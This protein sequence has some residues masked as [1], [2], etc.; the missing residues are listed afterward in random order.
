MLS[1]RFARADAPGFAAVASPLAARLAR[2]SRRR[3]ARGGVAAVAALGLLGFASEARASGYLTARYGS[4]MGTPA[5]P[6]AYAV[7]YNPAAMG[8][9]HGTNLIIDASVVARFASY[10]RA[11]T[12]PSADCQKDP[13]CVAANTGKGT[14]K[15]LLAL[16]YI[17]ATTDLG[18]KDFRLGLAGYIPYGGMATWDKKGG[19]QG[20]PG[21][22]DGPQRWH[23][24][25]GTILAMHAT[26]AASYTLPANL[27][28]GASVSG[29]YHTVGTVR[30][31]NADDGD[32]VRGPDGSLTEGR[33]YLK[34]NAFNVGATFG[35]YWAPEKTGSRALDHRLKLGVS[36]T[37]QPGF[38]ETRMAGELTQ[39][40]GS[41]V[42]GDIQKIDFLQTYPDIIRFGA[43]YKL[44]GDKWELKADVDFVRW[45]VFDRQC[46][47]LA[48]KNCNIDSATGGP[49]G[50]NDAEKAANSRDVVL[51]LKRDWQNA[52]G[53]R[54][55][56]SYFL[57]PE[58]ELF[59]SLGFSTSAVPKA[60]IDAN[61]IDSFRIYAA[62]GLRYELSKRLT[63]AGS[64]NHIFFMPVDNT[65]VSVYAKNL[66]PSRSPSAEGK[67]SST[68]GMLNANATL[69]F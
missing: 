18:T 40:L 57:S 58:V 32:V 29:I 34:A 48:G 46:V 22:T 63:L 31:R 37:S 10:E 49:A 36:Y 27:S 16:P 20:I 64:Y 28:L 19:V 50:A 2:G 43:A 67:Y 60:T 15:N 56:P 24:I 38:G 21:S 51:N 5:T 25:S 23:T 55:G 9:T 26:L 3:L 13:D 62:A 35:L 14:L 7:Y 33:S 6:N 1:R 54:A 30:A 53:F 12:A 65:G 41:G 61:T 42:A 39:V 44:P 4:D 8:G 11:A 45:S 47:V 59:G 66:Q 69:S 68:I 17:G 52:V